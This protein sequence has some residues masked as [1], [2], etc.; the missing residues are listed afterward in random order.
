MKT[1]E[2]MTPLEINQEVAALEGQRG[3]IV[4]RL[5]S[6]RLRLALDA[7][8]YRV[9]EILV[10]RHGQ[11]ARINHITSASQ[12]SVG[13]LYSLRGVYLKKDGAPARNPGRDNTRSRICRFDS[14][15]KWKPT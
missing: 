12:Y 14:W 5:Y 4:A 9:G 8:P 11:R 15:D 10:N 1:P 2:D 6:L 3:K 13:P 7:C